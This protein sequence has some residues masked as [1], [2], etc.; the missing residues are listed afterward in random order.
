MNLE[1]NLFKKTVSLEHLF[2]SWFL[3]RKGKRKR[4]DV[5]EYE[6]FLERNI[7]NLQKRLIKGRYKHRLYSSFFLQDPKTRHIRKAY[8]EDRLVHQ[9]VYSSLNIIYDSK[10]IYHLYSSR[11]GKG[12]H[13]A[14]NNLK[15][16]TRKVSKNYTSPC[17]AL[18]CDVRRFYDSVDQKILLSIISK[19]IKNAQ[20]LDLVEKI[21]CSFSVEEN[22]GMPI[23]NLTSQIFTSI[24]LN[25]LDKHIKHQLKIKYYMRFADDLIILSNDQYFLANLIT[26]LEDF[27]NNQLLL[28]LHPNK[29]RIKPLSQGFDF[30][31]YITF[32]HHRVIRTVTKRR[33][34]KKLSLRLDEYLAGGIDQYSMNQTLQS[35]L[36]ILSHADTYKLER[37]IINQFFFN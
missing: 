23:G 34:L 29:L 37:R 22:K 19:T 11:I 36:G 5:I 6:R 24:Y 20:F 14:V 12:T 2:N 28:K 18:K 7:F 9:A 15:K 35:Y 8:V 16:M 4:C 17:W 21:V 10:F 25:E 30:L 31:G 26:T 33:M 32:R 1:N 3:F 27:L 13:K